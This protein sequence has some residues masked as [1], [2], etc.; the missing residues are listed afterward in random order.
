MSGD[1]IS[2]LFED[3][4]KMY[5]AKVKES[6]NKHFRRWVSFIRFIFQTARVNAFDVVPVMQ[7][8]HDIITNGCVN[9]IKSG[10]WV[11]KRFHIDRKGVAEVGSNEWNDS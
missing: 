3:L 1:L 11:L 6:V 5:N 10:N 4:F 2:L 9:A 8:F 7:Q